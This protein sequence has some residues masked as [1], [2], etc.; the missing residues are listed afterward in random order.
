MNGRS[1][2]SP[3][4]HFVFLALAPP[5]FAEELPPLP[6]F[7]FL[8]QRGGGGALLR[9]DGLDAGGADVVEEELAGQKV[10]DLHLQNLQWLPL[11]ACLQN[12]PHASNLKSPFRLEEQAFLGVVSSEA[13]EHASSRD[14]TAAQ[15]R[16]IGI[17]AGRAA[18]GEDA[19]AEKMREPQS[20]SGRT[21]DKIEIDKILSYHLILSIRT[22]VSYHLIRG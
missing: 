14:M 13:H 11:F 9:S 2:F 12:P 1:P 8:G 7:I 19:R 6:F 17:A 22:I 15:P 3:D 4:S 5:V 21:I 18:G 10:H 20:R 16:C